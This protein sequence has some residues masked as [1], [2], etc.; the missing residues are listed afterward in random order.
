MTNK[1]LKKNNKGYNSNNNMY[2]RND[3]NSNNNNMYIRNEDNSNNIR[4]PPKLIR[5]NTNVHN[6]VDSICY[7]YST[8]TI[9][10]NILNN[11]LVNNNK[12]N[13]ITLLM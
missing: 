3:V 7:I 1:L 4:E 13:N 8:F 5:K 11:I 10:N 6:N 12:K 2:I 9:I